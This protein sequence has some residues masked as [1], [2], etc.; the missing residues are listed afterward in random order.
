MSWFARLF[1]R[2]KLYGDLAE[3][4]REHIAEKAEQLMR[5]GMGREEATRAARRAFGNATVIEERGR[6]VWQ[7][8]RLESIWAD[9][10]YA[11]RQLR[12]SPGFTTTA[13]LTLALG[14]G[15]NTAVFS[16][17]NA[18]LLRPLSFPQPDRIFQIEKMNATESSYTAS[19]PL[20]L[21]WREHNRVFEHVAAYS[22]LPVGFNLAQRGRP[23]RV[24]GLRV[25]ADF[26]RVLG[27]APQLGRNFT[28]DDDR[29]GSQH[30]VIL[31]NSLWHRRYNSDP[32]LVGKSI[33]ID[34]QAYTV[35]GVLPLGFQ[36]LATMPTSSAIEAWT[37][38]QLPAASRDPSST[39]ECIGRLKGGVTRQQAALEMTSLSR[40]LALGSSAVFPTSGT[41]NLLPLQQRITGETRPALLLLFGAVGFV[42]L[43]ACGN[44]ANLL[45]ARM[46]DRAREIGVRAALGASRLRIIRQILTES[47]LLAGMGGILGLLVAWL[48]NR[49]LVASAPLAISRTGAIN[50]D[51]QV[52]LFALAASL[53]TGIVFGLIPALRVPKIGAID[54]LRDG[55]SRRATAGRSHRRLSGALV[56]AETALSLMLLIAAGLLIESF[57]KLQQVNPGFNYDR[58]STFETTL[59]VAKYGN[60]TELQ[61]FVQQVTQRIQALPGVDSAASASSLPT[62]PTLNFPF[63]IE[64]GPTPSPGQPSGE[65]DYLIVSSEYFRAMRI[66]ML[67]GRALTESDTEHSPGV[68]VINQAMARKYWPNE[69]PI[70]KRIV[71]AKNLGP[72]W[73]DEAREVV[74]IAGDVKTD[75]LEE[76]APPSMYTPFAQV[77]PHMSAVLLGTIP[78]RWIVRTKSDPAGMVNQ[79]GDAVLGVDSEEPIAEARTMRDLLSDSL[80]RWR[81]N[82]LLLGAFAGIALVLA[83]VGIYGVIS[84]TVA[85]RT[86]EIGIRMALGAGRAS[87]VWIVLRQAGVLLAGGTV[88]G[89]AGAAVMSRVLK[90]F[91]YGVA[92][93]DAGVL[94]AVAGLM[95]SV[96]LIA[97]WKPARR[98]AKIDPMQ[99]LRS[100]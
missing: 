88:T 69:D 54:A 93:G 40:Q 49:I 58:L 98:A 18:V 46:G 25:S 1:R 11:L 7:W 68:V 31:G 94:F 22:V 3:E 59:S 6:E 20:F 38:L 21:Q 47:L 61:R 76:P 50:I 78:L 55:L 56:M 9:V 80:V 74:G 29:P 81:F 26:F 48:S 65:S 33:T 51:W 43:I 8:P 86:H 84:Y 70:G 37:P 5:E 96:G 30:V 28:V 23:E 35:I 90:G 16:L 10:K 75:S 15:A 64:G 71:I 66:P 99:A 13:V 14:I 97:A 60:P 4:M 34:G 36:F 17:I 44:V 87:V 89:L 19:I 100:E 85:Q 12:K 73:V 57:L 52:L 92:P 72:D 32:G 2:R 82:M 41:I 79:I 27:I 39:L 62:E 91:I 95:C 67:K 45:L 42:L 63:T 77:S 24:P 83:T 53:A